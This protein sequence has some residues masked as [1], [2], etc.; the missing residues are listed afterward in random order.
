[1]RRN[2]YEVVE[3]RDMA[4]LKSYVVLLFRGTDGGKQLRS[5]REKGYSE[6]EVM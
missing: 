5:S 1:M 3:R 2:S 6:D 4:K